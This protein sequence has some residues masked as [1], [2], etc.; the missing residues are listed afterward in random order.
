MF[1]TKYAIIGSGPA[2]FYAA[3]AIRKRDP[4][5]KL[6]MI[7]A[8]GYLPYFRPLTSYRI[9]DL[10]PKEKIFLRE[11]EYYHRH[12]I[13][14][15]GGKVTEVKGEEKILAYTPLSNNGEEKSA[16]DTQNARYTNRLHFEKLLIA[17]GAAPSKP[18]IPGIDTPG[19]YYLRTINDAEKIAARAKG[20]RKALLLGG[21]LVSLKTAYSLHKLGLETTL[22]I[23]SNRI[24]SQ[25]LDNEGAEMVARHLAEKGLGMVYQND[26]TEIHGNGSGVTGVTLADGRKLKTDLIV[27][28]KGVKPCTSFLKES[29]IEEENGIPV[30]EQLQTNLPD[31]Y[32][33]GDVVLSK[34]LLLEKPANNALWP[35]ATAQGEIAGANMSGEQLIYRGSMKMNAAEFFG[36][37]VIAAGL[38]RVQEGGADH[39]YE[40][41]RAGN[42]TGS[43]KKIRY[44]KL[45]FQEDLLVGYISIGENRKA[46]VLTNLIMSRRPLS[47]RHK[48]QLAEGNLSLPF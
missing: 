30:N 11:A 35:N 47:Q 20:R 33:A 44:L 27:V 45:V 32:A 46:G 41:F 43:G 25:M 13:E 2:A 40:I 23:A 26:I 8:E 19:V 1:S 17:S 28:G 42:S 3:Q 14:F 39:L 9:A 31:V 12:K 36:L 18:D 29:G 21:G 37:P 4:G 34:D 48:E 22:V 38:G 24:L 15:I 5:G 7:G 10:V 6:A 16:S